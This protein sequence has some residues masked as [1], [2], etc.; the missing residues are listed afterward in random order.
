MKMASEQQV[1]YCR[2]LFRK[3]KFHYQCLDDEKLRDAVLKRTGYDLDELEA[4][5]AQE[6]ISKLTVDIKR[7]NKSNTWF[8]DYDQW[9]AS[10]EGLERCNHGN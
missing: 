9:L 8:L 4:Y 1:K 2:L 10:E 7:Q 3:V 6:I 5:E